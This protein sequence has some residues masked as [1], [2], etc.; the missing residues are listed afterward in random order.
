M[1]CRF[2][3]AAA[4]R[5]AGPTD[6][7]VDEPAESVAYGPRARVA[8]HDLDAVERDAEL[9]GGDLRHRGARAGAD[10]LHRGDDR[11]AAVRRRRAIHAYDGGPPPPNQICD[12]MP[13]PCFHV[14]VERARTS[15]R[16]SQCF[17]ASS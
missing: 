7:V 5:T 17:C 14:S 10:V 1:I 6:G 8:E 16:R 11:D 12:A 15:S 4:A 13:T 2:A 3:S 9:L